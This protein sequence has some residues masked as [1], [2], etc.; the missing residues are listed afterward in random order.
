M[1][2]VQWALK[3]KQFLEYYVCCIKLFLNLYTKTLPDSKQTPV[4]FGWILPDGVGS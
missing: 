1:L 2:L 3:K 4:D